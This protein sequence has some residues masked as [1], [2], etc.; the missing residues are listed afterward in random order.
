MEIVDALREVTVIRARLIGE[1]KIVTEH[2]IEAAKVS[3]LEHDADVTESNSYTSPD[4]IRGTS[5]ISSPLLG[6][7][8]RG[9]MVK[10]NKEYVDTVAELADTTH[11]LK[12]PAYKVKVAVK[13][14]LVANGVES[15]STSPLPT[16]FAKK[17]P[18]SIARIGF[19][20]LLIDT[21]TSSLPVVE[22]SA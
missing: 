16:I 2:E 20:M 11:A 10:V 22:V 1:V 13:E 15:N 8:L 6:I 21:R 3:K 14:G 17:F 4:Q 12:V 18:V 19:L 5:M 7:S 9:V